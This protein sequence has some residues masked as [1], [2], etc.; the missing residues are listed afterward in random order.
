[1]NYRMIETKLKRLLYIL[2]QFHKRSDKT[3]DS[4]DE[5]LK[6]KFD[7]SPK[8]IG[9]LLDEVASEF[10]NIEVFKVTR[11]RAYRLIKPIDIFI[12]TFENSNDIGWLF[13]MAH[14]SDP[15]IFKE[16]ERYTKDSKHI[17]LF[18]NNPFEDVKLLEEKEV[19]KKLKTAVKLREYRK[20]TFQGGTKDNLKCLKLIYMQNNWYLAYVDERNRVLLARVSFIKNVEYASKIGSFQPSTIKKHLEFLKTIQNPLTLYNKPKKIAKLQVNKKSAKYFEEGMKKFLSSQKFIEKLED[21]S[22]VFSLEYT[23]PKEI[24]PF[25]QSWMSDMVILEPENLQKKYIKKL[26][27]AVLKVRLRLK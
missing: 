2:E 13:N 3:L 6:E 10:D 19:F 24:L 18:K 12:E 9:R 23:Q 16:L 25:I 27:E 11:K 20:I 5:D 22:V 4:Y 14:D 15:E 21:G 1:M 17:Y 8:Q 26:D 7:L